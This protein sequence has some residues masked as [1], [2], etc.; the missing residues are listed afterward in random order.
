MK[1]IKYV[2]KLLNIYDKN[3]ESGGLT[4]EVKDMKD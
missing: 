4:M 1:L 3:V 2:K